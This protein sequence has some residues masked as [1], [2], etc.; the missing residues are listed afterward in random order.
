MSLSN[1]L[2]NVASFMMSK[3]N[4]WHDLIGT[5]SSYIKFN[6]LKWLSCPSYSAITHDFPE[7]MASPKSWVTEPKKE[8]EPFQRFLV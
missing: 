8:D 3:S 6:T 7:R 1:V 5:V 4:S 2:V